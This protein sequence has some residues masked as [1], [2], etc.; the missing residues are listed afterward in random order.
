MSIL[1]RPGGAAHKIKTTGKAGG[2]HHAFKA[3][4]L[5]ASQDALNSSP[6]AEPSQAAAKAAFSYYAFVFLLPVNGSMYSLNDN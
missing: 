4:L 3:I 2:M 1:S 6:T 5:A